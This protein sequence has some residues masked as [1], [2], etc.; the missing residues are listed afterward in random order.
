MVT[1]SF[2]ALEEL[3]LPLMFLRRITGIERA[4]I[5]ALSRFGIFDLQVGDVFGFD[6]FERRV[7]CQPGAGRRVGRIPCWWIVRGRWGAIGLSAVDIFA[8]A[9][10]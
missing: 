2:L 4:K 6:E 9:A 10:P 7:A 3:D 8:G 5:S 1:F